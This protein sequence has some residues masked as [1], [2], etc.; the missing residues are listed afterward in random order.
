[1]A[2]LVGDLADGNSCRR[3]IATAFHERHPKDVGSAGHLL[4]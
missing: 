4:A 2:H 1:M 3:L